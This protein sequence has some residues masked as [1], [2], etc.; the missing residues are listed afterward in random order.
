VGIGRDFT[1]G[2]STYTL[3]SSVSAS[4]KSQLPYLDFRYGIVKTDT[5]QFG[6]SLGAAYPILKA[7]A[8]ASA[9]V[10]GPNGPIIGQ[11]VT[12]TAKESL[13]VPL[14][15]LAFEQKIGDSLSAGVLFNGIFAPVHPYVGS[16]FD[17]EAH[18]DWYATRNLGFGGGFEY[19]KFNLKREETNS[20]VNFAY[21]YYGPRVYVILSF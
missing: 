21:S 7:E 2:D 20:Y 19:T 5:T 6:V 13:P 9:G 10:I 3:G 15:G 8:T 18:I 11:D 16:I 1:F 12:K 17:A 14:L 4:M